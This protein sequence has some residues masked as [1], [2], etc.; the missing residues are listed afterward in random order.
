[1]RQELD[2]FL[3]AKYPLIFAE[4]HLPMRE[5]CMCWGFSCGDGWF[6]LIDT[7]CSALQGT[8]ERM[9]PPLPQPVAVQVKEKFGGLRFYVRSA[10]DYQHGMIDMAE[11]LSTRICEECG[12]PGQM[13]V[14]RDWHMVRCDKHVP[15]G[16]IS[17]REWALRE[18]QSWDRKRT[19]VEML[20]NGQTIPVW[21][22]N[23]VETV[24]YPE[25]PERLA[26]LFV[27]YIERERLDDGPCLWAA[28]AKHL[29][30]FFAEEMRQ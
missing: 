25:M 28:K 20:W 2:D 7:L 14:R 27:S 22:I 16:A 8:V 30:D 10:D 9:R 18:L 1:M 11:E 12:A 23:G 26:E 4:R 6:R 13:L 5:T 19:N 17:A 24:F 15:A 3:V 29:R 21:E